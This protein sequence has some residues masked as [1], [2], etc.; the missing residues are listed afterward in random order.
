MAAEKS[1]SWMTGAGTMDALKR[2]KERRNKHIPKGSTEQFLD[3]S[4]FKA[5]FMREA[6]KTVE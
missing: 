2:S 5:H 3:P 6:T 4:E 1:G